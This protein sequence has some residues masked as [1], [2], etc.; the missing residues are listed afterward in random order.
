MVGS[1]PVPS[2]LHSQ[3]DLLL[4]L[5][6]WFDCRVHAV[7]YVPWAERNIFQLSYPVLLSVFG[8]KMRGLN[9]L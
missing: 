5:P 6:G 4:A 1:G 3:W 7:L 2:S 9:W 8:L